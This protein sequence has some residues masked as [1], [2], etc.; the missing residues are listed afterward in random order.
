MNSIKK[1]HELKIVA[2]IQ[3]RMGSTRLPGKTMVNICGKPL[4]QHVIERVRCCK[5]IHEIIVATTNNEY[6]YQ[7]QC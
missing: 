1:P 5:N 2:I 4:L 7:H 3:A 6:S